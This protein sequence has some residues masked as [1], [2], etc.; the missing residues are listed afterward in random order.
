MKNNYFLKG[1][2][3]ELRQIEIKDLKKLSQLIAKWVN[4]GIVTYYLFT[5]QKPKNSEQVAADFKKLLDEE[6]NIIFLIVDSKTNKPIGYAG[7]YEI[8][9][10]ARKAESRILIGEK[11][12]WGRGYGKDVIEL[13]TFYGFDRLNLNRIY[14][15]YTAENKGS[16]RIYENA[17]YVYEGTLKEDIYRNSR[18]YDSIRMALLRKD[19]YKKFYKSHSE[20]FKQ[21]FLKK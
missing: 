17:G 12:F 19:Y 1:G 18:Y 11:S 6:N 15:G 7:L 16:G 4:D 20:R 5:G 2:K 21:V 10:T 3:V 14:L 13:L 9:P 8:H